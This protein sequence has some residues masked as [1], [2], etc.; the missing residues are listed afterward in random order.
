MANFDLM[1]LPAA[2][3]PAVRIGQGDVSFAYTLA[4]SLTGQPAVVVP[5]GRDPDGLPIGVQIA[6]RPWRDHQAIAAAH[7]LEATGG[8]WRPPGV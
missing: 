3:R 1:L 8:W 5:Y 2:E 6:A 7:A 4:F